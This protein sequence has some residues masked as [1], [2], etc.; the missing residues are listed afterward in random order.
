MRPQIFLGKFP[1]TILA[2]FHLHGK[3]KLVVLNLAVG[4]VLREEKIIDHFQAIDALG[5]WR[6]LVHSLFNKSKY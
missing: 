6:F 3:H 4:F 1:K 5:Y 2:S